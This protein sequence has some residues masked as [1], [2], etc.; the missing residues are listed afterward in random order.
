MLV[1]GVCWVGGC[2]FYVFDVGVGFEQFGYGFWVYVDDG[3]VWDIVDDN[4]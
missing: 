4:W 2:V 1:G 3:V